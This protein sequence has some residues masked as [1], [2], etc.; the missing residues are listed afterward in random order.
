MILASD[1]CFKVH[2]FFNGP[3]KNPGL[4]RAF[5]K[6]GC[7]WICGQIILLWT[8]CRASLAARFPR[9]KIEKGPRAVL[10]QQKLFAHIH[11]LRVG[12]LCLDEHKI[13]FHFI[14][15]HAIG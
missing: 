7:I 13:H 6:S 9:L 4:E 2:L 15:N 10:G 12:H 8:I 1:N 14:E 11:D 3:R 5:D